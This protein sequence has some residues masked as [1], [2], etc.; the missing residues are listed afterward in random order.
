MKTSLIV[1]TTLGAKTASIPQPILSAFKKHAQNS[2]IAEVHVI[3]E[4]NLTVLE[5]L[6]KDISYE[7]KKFKY[8]N[9]EHRP[10]FSM[11]ISY[12]NQLI[13]SENC[14]CALMNADISFGGDDDVALCIS[15]LNSISQEDG[16]V[17][18]A[19]TR[20]DY[21]KSAWQ[22]T[23]EP[24]GL[25]NNISADCWIFSDLINLPQANFYSMGEV[26]CDLMLAYDLVTSGFQVYNPCLD[27]KIHHNESDV[28]THEFYKE[29]N[30]KV[31]NQDRLGLHC[32]RHRNQPFQCFG[33]PWVSSQWLKTGY[34]PPAYE[35]YSRR[36]KKLYITLLEPLNELLIYSL[37]SIELFAKE[38]DF[39]LFFV[40]DFDLEN[41]FSK[42][43]P[44]ILVNR[45]VYFAKL[46]NTVD[47]F[48]FQLV[49]GNQW[50]FNRLAIVSDPS[51]LTSSIADYTEF[52]LL[53]VRSYVIQNP[54]DS[55]I[56]CPEITGDYKSLLVQRY[57]NFVDQSFVNRSKNREN[58]CLCTLITSVY[59]SDNFI[60]SFFANCE[61]LIG[62]SDTIDHFAFISTLSDYEADC[63]NDWLYRNR[64]AILFWNKEDPGLYE[65]W[66]IGV[67]LAQT[68]FVSNANVD[69]L[70]HQ[71]HVVELVA[72]LRNNPHLCVA[73]SALV[74]F[75]T[76]VTNIEKIDSSQP[77]YA[78]ESGEFGFTS[79]AHL[80]IME[81]GIYKLKPH[82]LPHCMPIWRRQLHDIY[83]FFDE[84]R[85]GTY[86]DWA[87]WL[88]VTKAGERGYLNAAPLSYYH[89]NLTS[90]NRRANNLEQ[91]HREI[92]IEYVESFYFR[93]KIN[94]I[95]ESSY[96]IFRVNHGNQTP[97]KPKLN[98]WGLTH[99]FG[100]HRHSF[101][102]L[103]DSLLPLDVREDGIKFIP[104]I[105]RYFVW[106]DHEGEAA[107]TNPQPLD[108]EWIG[109][110]HVPFDSPVWF[111]PYN[112]P[113]YIFQTQLWIDS[114]PFCKGLICLT[115]DLQKD[116]QEWYPDLPTLAV[117]F[118]TELNHV[119][120]FDFTAYQ[121]YPRVVQ[122]GDW[123][124][125]LQSIYQLHTES[126][127]KL[128]LI[129]PCTREY[130]RRE[131]EVFGDYR[132]DSV[133]ELEFV[134]N[135]EYDSLL[136]SSVVLCLLYATAAN[137]V[138]IECIARGTPILINP[139][140]SVVEYLGENYPLYVKDVHEAEI[141]L[142]KENQIKAASDYLL[143]RR[144]DIDLSFEGWLKKI[145][146]S[147]FYKGL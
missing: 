56:L 34:H 142:N 27:I 123:L 65:C 117:N 141:V 69:D 116:L 135:Q 5:N 115:Q 89:I 106:G 101:N 7:F 94:N 133:T 51:R 68:E 145:A 48:I 13:V 58:K 32:V 96:S 35:M 33:I 144:N 17:V 1:I 129:K 85:Y 126:H 28:K 113:E 88:K 66:N 107:S 97:F 24:T 81:N 78:D 41:L 21:I 8:I 80:E 71:K 108:K 82:N 4:D 109:V 62:Y 98:L 23:Y 136:S 103:I 111:E 77:W 63:I 128:I 38:H 143:K 42:L 95:E 114:L 84:K 43:R 131:I 36:R 3:S 2:H 54:S 64:N 124:R 147:N 139:L 46:N 60:K 79:L 99:N 6:C 31:S 9:V 12:A 127:Q 140:P 122:V 137:N 134:S 118:P 55:E 70:R 11:L 18:Y 20:R 138:V 110:I 130:M 125:K 30:Q 132:N 61:Q 93:L 16:K 14:I 73:S 40:T 121:K 86:A 15:S 44:I 26:H 83:G 50:S 100:K 39:D 53:D 22:L 25:P 119:K 75:E 105:E 29:Q 92:E 74:P 120:F 104:F 102:K 72:D 146:E 49:K 10:T 90:H 112:S 57:E 67:R 87:F 52:I 47:E 19:L 76:Y 91:L 37:F 59:Q 45:N